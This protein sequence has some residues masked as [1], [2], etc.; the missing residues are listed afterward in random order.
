MSKS[1]PKETNKAK[2]LHRDRAI[3]LNINRKATRPRDVLRGNGGTLG[4]SR[5]E[6]FQ[7]DCNVSFAAYLEGKLLESI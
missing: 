6:S 7:K 2:A 4:E 3:G 1:P 5:S